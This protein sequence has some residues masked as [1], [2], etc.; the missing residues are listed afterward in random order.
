MAAVGKNTGVSPARKN[1]QRNVPCT[2]VTER[3]VIVVTVVMATGAQNANISVQT[4]A[5][6]VKEG[7]VIVII[8]PVRMATGVNDA[9]SVEATA[10]SVATTMA[11]VDSANMAAGARFVRMNVQRTVVDF[12]TQM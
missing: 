12:V 11:A 9:R 6:N 8:A 2:V 10:V 5:R 7:Q 4:I 1:A 3:Q